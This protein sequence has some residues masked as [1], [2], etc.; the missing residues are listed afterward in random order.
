MP[1][2]LSLPN[3]FTNATKPRPSSAI[4]LGNITPPSLSTPSEQQQLQ[5]LPSPPSSSQD[6]GSNGGREEEDMSARAPLLNGNHHNGNG[7]GGG[8]SP[9]SDEDGNDDNEEHTA[10]LNL[11]YSNYADEDEDDRRRVRSMSSRAG[12][13]DEDA[14]L[15]RSAGLAARNRQVLEHMK[16][17]TSTT[18][19]TPSPRPST[20]SSRRSPIPRS[21]ST[22]SPSVNGRRSPPSLTRQRSI[23]GS[24]TEREHPPTGYDDSEDYYALSPPP[25][26]STVPSGS[27]YHESQQ[28]KPQYDDNNNNNNNNSFE[29]NNRGSTSRA[30]LR[31]SPK[32]VATSVSNGTISRRRG[33]PVLETMSGERSVDAIH[34]LFTGAISAAVNDVPSSTRTSPHQVRKPLPREFRDRPSLEVRRSDSG[35]GGSGS[36][37]SQSPT[38]SR[39]RPPSRIAEDDDDQYAAYDR[40]YSKTRP[41]TSNGVLNHSDGVNANH[42]SSSRASQTFFSPE[43][44]ASTSTLSASSSGSGLGAGKY[45]TVRERRAPSSSH[46]RWAS[47]DLNAPR[48]EH[49]EVNLNNSRGPVVGQGRRPWRYENRGGSAESALAG[50]RTLVGEGLRAAGLTRRRDDERRDEDVFTSS[51]PGTGKGK[52]QERPELLIPTSTGITHS[53][54]A[55]SAVS[56]SR[57]ATEMRNDRLARLTNGNPKASPSSI[58]GGSDGGERDR[59]RDLRVPYSA[60]PASRGESD[61]IL[62]NGTSSSSRNLPVRPVTSMDASPD[63]PSR[64]APP[65]LR[66]YRS[67]FIV[68]QRNNPT[69]PPPLPLL[70][71][72]MDRR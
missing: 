54:S 39:F 20:N 10:K 44:T 70:T 4:F 55:S 53:S 11:K 3:N 35:S 68:A 30:S 5:Q 6:S 7:N 42:R 52:E 19:D 37:G 40:N 38:T 60:G 22:I 43:L 41:K 51:R 15:E 23:S 14:V 50:G 71:P 57:S 65:P 46:S 1:P 28:K 45:N 17:I 25:S 69:I 67:S 18:R 56:E 59:Y 13:R 8:F 72:A 48:D 34:N 49:D 47:E 24:E 58:H 61:R 12:F 36:R 32:H 66:S 33:A 31:R 9:S 16:A 29:S 27:N 63:R 62:P 21:R 26:T 2:R 64:T